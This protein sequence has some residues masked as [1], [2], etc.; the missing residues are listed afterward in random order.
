MPKNQR[1]QVRLSTEQYNNLKTKADR[2]GLDISSY[3]R[4]VALRTEVVTEYSQ[5]FLNNMKEKYHGKRKKHN[6]QNETY[7]TQNK[8]EEE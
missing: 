3:V 1:I 5:S 4:L 8:E 2:V 7:K 6:Y